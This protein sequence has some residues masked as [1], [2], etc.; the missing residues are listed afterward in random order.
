MKTLSGKFNQARIYLENLEKEAE[1]QIIGFLNSPVFKNSSIAIMPD[2]HSGKGSVIGLTMSLND[3][4]IPNVVGVD[5]GCGVLAFE[6]GKMEFSF[7]KLDHFI[8]KKI[9]SGFEINDQVEESLELD[10]IK[11]VE[12][13]SKKIGLQ[14]SKMLKAVGSLGGGNHYIEIDRDNLGHFWLNIHSGSRNFGLQIAEYHQKLARLYCS[15]NKIDAGKD[16]EYLP[17]NEGG[18]DY[19]N[20]MKTAQEFA[21]LNR[22]TMARR[23][24]KFFNLEPEQIRKIESVHNYIDFEGKMIRKGAIAAKKGQDIIIPL[25]MRDGA[26]IGKGLGNKDWNFSA[27]H[28]AGR[29]MSRHKAFRQIQLEDYRKSMEG[30]WSSCVNKQTLDESPFAYKNSKEILSQ[31]GET[32]Q[33][34][35]FLKP[36]YNFKA[37]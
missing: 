36:V 34:E 14:S 33:I 30:I 22:N 10:F 28:G 15:R 11:K 18:Q 13:I 26:V 8:R 4:I 1:N 37:Y 16:L 24:L 29:V 6:L 21:S 17:I 25:N 9:P 35:L 3:Y 19:L 31:I 23:I 20:D 12:K 7:E 2:A 27:P 32:A 5:I